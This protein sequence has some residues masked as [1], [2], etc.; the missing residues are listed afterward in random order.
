VEGNRI[1]TLV[2]EGL[3]KASRDLDLELVVRE[4]PEGE[5]PGDSTLDLI[6][7]GYNVIVAVAWQDPDMLL[8]LAREHAD[9]KFVYFWHRYQDPL[10]NLIGFMYQMDQAGFLAGTLA[11]RATESRRVAVVGGIPVLSVE[12][13]VSGFGQGVRHTCPECEIIVQF[14]DS[15][16]DLA[17]GEEIGRQVVEEG[18]DVVFNA[19]G[20]SGS[21]AIRSSAQQGAWVIGVDLDEYPSTFRGGK[22]PNANRLLGSVIMRTDRQSYETIER[23]VRGDFKP[24]SFVLGVAQGSIEFLPSPENAHPRWPEL[25][26]YVHQVTEGL[27][28]GEIQP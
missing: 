26:Q 13:L 5:P 23:I 15:F 21:A 17:L 25:E 9:V 6:T 1:T 10:P 11:G 24:G 16:D 8:G 7:Q 28:R 12:Q 27:R 19:A 22:V 14:T 2:F 4:T 3:Q 20:A 18:A